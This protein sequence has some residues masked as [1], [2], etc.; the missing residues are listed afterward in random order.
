MRLQSIPSA[1]I[2]GLPQDFRLAT[3]RILRAPTLATGIVLT[4]GLGLGSAAA[5]FATSEAALLDAVPFPRP[6]RLVHLWELRAHSD[7]GSPTSYPTLLA[8]RARAKSFSALEG[9]DPSNFIVGLGDAANMVRGAE[10]TTGLFRLLDVPMARGRD[11]VAE[12]ATQGTDVAIVSERFVRS[13]NG[14]NPLG[15]TVRVNGAPH[16]VIGILPSTFSFAL[17]QDADIFVPLAADAQR[18][19]D[20]TNRSIR[21]IGR[22]RDGVS[23]A[24]AQADLGSVMAAL[25]REQPAALSGRGVMALT[26]REAFLGNLTTIMATLLGAVMLLLVVMGTNLALLMLTQYVS[27]RPE[28]SM[29][30][31]LGATRARIL[32]QLLVESLPPSLLGAA[33]AMVIGQMIAG[34]LV[35]TIPD[36]V[37]IGMPYLAH[38]GL[39]AR[40]I[41]V[42]LGI[43]IVLPVGFGLCP[44]LLTTKRQI[45]V[46]GARIT[47]SR[48]DRRLRQGL[49]AAQLALT[50]VLL[51]ASGLLIVSFRNLVGRDV[52]FRNP[53]QIVT[54]RA[55]L[56]G[57]RY[58][59]PVAQQ[60][61][62]EEVIARAAS[63]PG[64]HNAG[65]IDEVPGGGRGFTTFEPSDRPTPR[66]EQ[67]R[68]MMRI[69]GGR[70]FATMDIQIVA[71][72]VF[73]SGDRADTRRVAVVSA[74][75]AKLLATDGA[76]LGRMVRLAGAGDSTW[77]VVGIVGDVQVTALD[78]DA[79]PTVYLTHLQ[80]PENRMTLV[81]RTSVGAASIGTQLRA[82][83]KN[84]DSD[85]PVYA[86]TTI[87]E[88]LS[89]SRAVFSRKFPMILCVLFGAAALALSLVALYAI[90]LHDV[91][92]RRREF[93]IR[94][95]LGGAPSS[96]R[97]LIL[98]D[99]LIVSGIGSVAGVLVAMMATRSMQAVLFGIAAFDWRVY[100]LVVTSVLTAA[101]V[102]TIAPVVR[103]GSVNPIAAL[104]AD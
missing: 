23:L 50:V 15:M 56:A 19:A 12:D 63:L 25:A 14:R 70:Y 97:R 92:A 36:G 48:G 93:G 9:Y 90:C 21:V 34:E 44:A 66:S 41:A 79:P 60:Q 4:I 20:W 26:L 39:D 99:A 13:A 51:V 69:V 88:Q 40:V 80:W 5:I 67:P 35:S 45:H 10:V 98:K 17:L 96:I 61:F 22:L 54:A 33:L 38:A 101:V 29:R 58:A 68:A 8:W 31:A 84:I 82:I 7:E 77:E 52:G 18:R 1:L 78:I 30:S 76:T 47:S 89:Q 28:L 81:L 73:D 103:G 71:G 72:R 43:A 86:V 83:V 59:A 11:F 42:M 6:D 2:A 57:P 62:Y 32:R 95:A 49:V 64:V 46:L 37:R 104:R 65:M 74:A 53:E 16:V 91:L 55:P 24:R 102:A 27:R 87:A 3:R 100:G 94:I 75:F 85:V